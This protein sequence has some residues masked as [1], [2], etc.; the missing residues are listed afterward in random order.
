[1]RVVVID[2]V[3]SAEHKDLPTA[4]YTL[5]DNEMISCDIY[6]GEFSHAT[7]CDLIIKQYARGVE[8]ININILGYDNTCDIGKLILA[9]KWCLSNSVDIINI[10]AGI[11]NYVDNSAEVISLLEL[12]NKIN[13]KGVKI[14]SAQ[15][16]D[17]FATIPAKFKSVVSVETSNIL[18]AA[19]NEFRSSDYIVRGST[20]LCVNGKAEKMEKCNSFSCALVSAMFANGKNMAKIQRNKNVVIF[21]TDCIVY[22]LCNTIVNTMKRLFYKKKRNDAFECPVICINKDVAGKIAPLLT[23]E[24]QKLGYIVSKISDYADTSTDNAVTVKKTSDAKYCSKFMKTDLIIY[25]VC[26][27]VY[28]DCIYIERDGDFKLYLNDL[29]YSVDEN[30]FFKKLEELLINDY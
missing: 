11:I 4:Y 8:L 9:L 27:R 21:S 17:G 15:D 25:I 13:S 18:L 1:M 16:N 23:T 20:Y 22:E 30:T 7:I 26:N 29:I 5:V 3:L 24:F 19:N 6:T 12:C 14:V 2:G 28:R 10:S